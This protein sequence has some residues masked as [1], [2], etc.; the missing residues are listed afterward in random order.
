MRTHRCLPAVVLASALVCGAW[1]KTQAQTFNEFIASADAA[2]EQGQ[3]SLSINYYQE[4]RELQPRNAAVMR[5][6]GVAYTKMGMSVHAEIWLRAALSVSSGIADREAI[7]DEAARQRVNTL[8]L[9]RELRDKGLRLASDARVCPYFE[10]LRDLAGD[11]AET[12]DTT[13]ALETAR[14]IED[15]RCAREDDHTYESEARAYDGIA[16]AL[17][18][19]GDAKGAVE[20]AQ[21]AWSANESRKDESIYKERLSDELDSIITRKVGKTLPY[22][23]SVAPDPVSYTHLTLPTICSV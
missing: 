4:A 18:H 23:I 3:W 5:N 8:S 14:L 9:V 20:A 15:K 13:G 1:S 22:G 11:Q 21:K 7:A 12:G 17:A 16:V 2:R 19:Q 6:I 10:T